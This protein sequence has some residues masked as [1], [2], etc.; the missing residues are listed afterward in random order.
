MTD[1]SLIDSRSEQLILEMAK[2]G[3]FEIDTV[4][5][6]IW[7][8]AKLQRGQLMPLERRRAEQARH[9]GYLRV[10]TMYC[11]VRVRVS[12]H[13]VIYLAGHGR[14][15]EGLVIDHKNGRKDDNRLA[16]LQA[17]SP[18]TNTRRYYRKRA[19]QQS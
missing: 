10:R 9:D 6:E 19:K 15:P 4:L 8:V 5:G 1:T 7:R 13:R 2:Q 11:S 16:N 14:I 12:A 17:V 3:V 18:S